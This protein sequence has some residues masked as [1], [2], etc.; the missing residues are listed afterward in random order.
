MTFQWNQLTIQRLRMEK[1]TRAVSFRIA[2]ENGSEWELFASV[3]NR[4]QMCGWEGRTHLML[5]QVTC[6]HSNSYQILVMKL[7]LDSRLPYRETFVWVT[8]TWCMVHLSARTAACIIKWMASAPVP[9]W[10]ID[11]YMYC[12]Q[13]YACRRPCVR[14]SNHDM[15]VH[16]LRRWQNEIS[17]YSPET[18]PV[19]CNC[20]RTTSRDSLSRP[21]SRLGIS[22]CIR[23]IV[24]PCSSCLS[25]FES[26]AILI[27]PL[28][29]SKC[30]CMIQLD[31]RSCKRKK[32]S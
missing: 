24:L 2:A 26:C 3:I 21:T 12:W 16:L 30:Q 17:R 18:V 4:W 31:G 10:W 32:N 25:L 27:F 28:C 19:P 23:P 8:L 15:V 29:S 20:K 1:F 13:I 14:P 6:I 5:P 9:R 11:S 22:L 7:E